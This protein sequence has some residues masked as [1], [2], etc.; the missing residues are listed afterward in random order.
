MS[1]ETP[2]IWRVAAVDEAMAARYANEFG[3]P[4]PLARLLVARAPGG[5]HEASGFL[6]L[7][8]ADLSDPFLVPGMLEAALRV[9]EA[10]VN[11]E[12]ILIH[13]DYDVDGIAGVG[14]LLRVLGE[15][16]ATPRHWLPNRLRDGYGF[17]PA[18]LKRCLAET[19]DRPALIITTD[20]GTNEFETIQMAAKAGIDVVVTDHHEPAGLPPPA[21]AVVNPKLDSKSELR[22]LAGVGVAFKLCH[23]LIE[24][25]REKKTQQAQDFDL[26]RHLDW[27]A[28]GTVADIVPLKG[29]NRILVSHG[30]RLINE[31]TTPGLAALMNVASI[32]K[33]LDTY[34]IGFVIGPRIN[35]AGRLGDAGRAMELLLTEQ[36]ARA[37]NL[38]AEL[39][40]A[41]RERQEIEARI[42]QEA[43]SDIDSYF[44]G[45]HSF[46]LAVGRSGWHRGVIGNVASRLVALYRRPV[47]VIGFDEKGVGKGSCRGL[48]GFNMLKAI[49]ACSDSLET[50]GGHEAAAGIGLH[51]ERF[52]EFH[53][54][55]NR[56]AAAALSGKD[57]SPL[58]EIA[59]H[60]ELENATLPFM[61]ALERFS[62]FGVE[63]PEPVWMAQG[64]QAA[65]QRQVGRNHLRFELLANGCCR[66]AIAFNRADVPL[67][68]GLLDVAFR[69]RRDSYAGPGKLQLHVVDIRPS[70]REQP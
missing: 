31:A 9:F 63:N 20:C 59:G 44:D 4:L 41:N 28:L 3:L 17:T 43:C 15:L 21:V 1:A 55:F 25:C 62:P 69:L 61:E 66:Q 38:A 23:A 52:N 37:R 42:L 36:P 33:P 11:N 45:E 8:L 27:V 22:A 13:G 5:T 65:Q 56:A 16:G 30:L 24:V 12:S 19:Q 70:Q 46:G 26:R 50:F 57:L 51:K 18:S 58:L 64:V 68:N 35:A 67:P 32:R 14:L 39:H 34:H 54:A 53:E 2:C 6:D 60:L 48:K 49:D 29:E 10:V 47:A 40:A 7:R